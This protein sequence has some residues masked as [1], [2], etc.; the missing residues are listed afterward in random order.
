[1]GRVTIVIRT[2]DS[3]SEEID[4]EAIAEALS[5]STKLNMNMNRI[6]ASGTARLVSPEVRLLAW[7]S[8]SKPHALRPTMTTLMATKA[9]SRR[10]RTASLIVS[11]AIV[12]VAFI[13]RPA[14]RGSGL[15]GV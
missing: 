1:M 12:R 3:I 13:A 6:S 11:A 2:P 14:A 7:L 5:A 15:R 4:G 10:R 8:R 9:S